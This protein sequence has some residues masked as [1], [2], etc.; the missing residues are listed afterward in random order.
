MNSRTASLLVT[1][2]LS[3]A[4]TTIPAAAQ[5]VTDRAG[6]IKL[7]REQ[8]NDPD[9]D[10][11]TAYIEQAIETAGATVKRICIRKALESTDADIRNLGLR[12][13]LAN[14]Q[15]LAF[16]TEMP[17]PL[18]AAYK[19]AAGKDKDLKQVDNYYIS[20]IYRVVQNNLVF[21][22]KEGSVT[23]AQ[24]VWYPLGSISE[25]SDSYKGVAT[26]VGDEVNWTGGASLGVRATCRVT[27][28]I[29]E[30]ATLEGVLHCNDYWPIPI[31]APLL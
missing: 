31:K 27:A 25:A 15:Q 14:I 18:K 5:Q 28:K 11:R 4:S 8:C 16:K 1:L 23:T 26:V 12:A 30:G 3:G 7:W 17:E 2:A 29:K 13:A 6:E 20:K 22:I 10:L 19:K 21:E 9:V 24:S